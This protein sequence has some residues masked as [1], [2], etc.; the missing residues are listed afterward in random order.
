VRALSRTLGPSS[1]GAVIDLA[2]RRGGEPADFMVTV[3]ER[4]ET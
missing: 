2:A 1:V 4:P 3:G